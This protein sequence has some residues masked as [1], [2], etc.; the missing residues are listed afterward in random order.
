M[1]KLKGL[2]IA[3][4]LVCFVFGILYH[5][6]NKPESGNQITYDLPCPSKIETNLSLTN[7]YLRREN[8]FPGKYTKAFSQVEIDYA[9]NEIYPR[10]NSADELLNTYFEATRCGDKL[11]A[12]LLSS[13][14]ISPPSEPLDQFNINFENTWKKVSNKKYSNLFI[15][16]I[17]ENCRQKS[18][19]DLDGE[20]F[21]FE[22]NDNLYNSNNKYFGKVSVFFRSCSEISEESD[23][24]K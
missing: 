1:N 10:I 15:C 11:L 13:P 3:L 19:V 4:L 18:Y 6:K 7:K 22:Y 16:K 21:V 20:K 23:K 17:F 24:C 8:N 2:V 9:E 14:A 5:N 12:K